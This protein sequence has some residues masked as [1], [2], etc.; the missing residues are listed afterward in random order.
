MPKVHRDDYGIY[1]RC[2]GYKSRP[3][4]VV[5]YSHIFRMDDGGLQEGDTVKARHISGTPNTRIKLNSGQVIY[6]CHDSETIGQRTFNYDPPER[7]NLKGFRI[8]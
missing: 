2:G 7:F 3:G 6:W 8:L 1:I 5:G 4:N